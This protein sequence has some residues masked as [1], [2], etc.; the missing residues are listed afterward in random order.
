MIIVGA[1]MGVERPSASGPVR[2]SPPA[3]SASI[4]GAA[5]TLGYFALIESTPAAR[6]VGKMILKLRDP[7][8]G[9]RQPD[10]EQ[11]VK[12]NIYIAARPAHPDPGARLR[13]QPG[14]AGRRS[15]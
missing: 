6:R 11:A 9:R 8:P 14:R 15:S 2:A 13:R 10:L 4:I 12:R 5:I 7:R 3:R 1:I